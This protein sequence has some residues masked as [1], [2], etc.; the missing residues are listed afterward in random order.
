SLVAG[1]VATTWHADRATVEKVRAVERFNDVRHLAHSVLFD[2]DDAVKNLPGATVVR[3][4]LVKDALAYL[5]SLNIEAASDPALQRELAAAYERVGDVR[6]EVYGAS[7]GD[8]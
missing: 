2:Y 8:M 1:L 7:I 3:G 5:D 4:R 6:G